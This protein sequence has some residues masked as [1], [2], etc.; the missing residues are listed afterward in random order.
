MSGH[1]PGPWTARRDPCHFDTLSDVIGGEYD[2]LRKPFQRLHVSVGGFASTAEQESNTRLIA[3]A[4]E[5]LAALEWIAKT[6]TGNP[7]DVARVAIL[8]ATGGES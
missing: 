1:T 6:N 8:K 2:A 5:L 4:P 7:G 3:A